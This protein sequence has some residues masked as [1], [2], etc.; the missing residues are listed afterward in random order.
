MTRKIPLIFALSL[1]I[2]FPLLL[3]FAGK[4]GYLHNKSLMTEIEQLRYEQE[5]L[6]LQVQ[7]LSDQKEQMGSRDAL[8]DA[9]FKYGY[10]SDGEKVY[11]FVDSEEE[12]NDQIRAQTRYGNTPQFEG[13]PTQVIFALALGISSLGT[14]CYALLE[15]RWRRPYEFDA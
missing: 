14:V 12:S 5:V 6:T 9:A 15:K 1:G 10:Q 2:S 4:G 11:Y 13:W 8:R 7:S 3:A